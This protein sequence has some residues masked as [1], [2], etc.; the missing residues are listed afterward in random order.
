MQAEV[1]QLEMYIR[2][3]NYNKQFSFHS[4]VNSIVSIFALV[5][6]LTTKY[7]RRRHY[8]HAHF[9]VTNDF[10]NRVGHDAITNTSYILHFCSHFRTVGGAFYY[11]EI[12]IK[13]QQDLIPWYL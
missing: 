8:F 6:W 5:F 4:L 12:G 13:T 10:E 9:E 3:C 2:I 7:Q 11:L 1:Q